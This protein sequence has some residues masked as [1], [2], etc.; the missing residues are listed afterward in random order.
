MRQG[1]SRR[2]VKDRNPPQGGGPKGPSAGPCHHRTVG[3]APM[4]PQGA[5]LC[6]PAARKWRTTGRTSGAVGHAARVG[7]AHL[8]GFNRA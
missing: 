6:L 8:A 1:S 4:A 3:A 5:L 2:P 7:P